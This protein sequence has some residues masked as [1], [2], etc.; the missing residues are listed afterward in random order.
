MKFFK[1]K[2]CCNRIFELLVF[3]SC[4]FL[5][6][7]FAQKIASGSSSDTS[8]FL[9]G[10]SGTPMTCG[11]SNYGQGGD[12]TY[13]ANRTIPISVVGLTDIIAMSGGL[14]HSLFLKSDGT[15]WACG[16]NNYGQ[17]GNITTGYVA[18]PLQLSGL[19]D[20]IAISAGRNHSLFLKSDGT[21][22]ACGYNNYGQLGDGSTINR[23]SP[24]QVSGL[25]GIVSLIGGQQYSLFL[26]NDG[27]V[28]GCGFNGVG[29]LGDGSTIDK[30][31]PV[32]VIGLTNDIVSIAAGISHSL[33]LK[34]DGS[35]WACG[36]NNNG[37]LG[38]G[39]TINRISPIHVSSL[40]DI[41]AIAGGGF[42]FSLF[43]KND[44]TVWSCGNNQYG[45]L[46]DGTTTQRNTPIQMVGPSCIT[47]IA[48]GWVH[49]LLLKNDTTFWSCGYNGL[50][51]LGDGTNSTRTNAVQV[52]LICCNN[53]S[54]PTISASTNPITSGSST[55]LHIEMGNLNSA[56][57]WKW[58]ANSCGGTFINTSTEISVSPTATT[59]YY[60][61]GEGGC[62][63]PGVCAS[64]T[65]IVNPVTPPSIQYNN[66]IPFILNE[67]ITPLVPI[68]SGGDV[69]A[70]IY[71]QVTTFASGFDSPYN[72]VSDTSGNVFVSDYWLNKIYKVTPAG[73]VTIFAGSGIQE[74]I[75]G[76]GEAAGF[77]RPLGMAVDLLGNLYVAD[78]FGNKI[79]KIFPTGEVT[80]YAGSGAQGSSDGSSVSA[81][82][83][84]PT[85]VVVDLSNN[86]YVA[87]RHNNKIRKI[88]TS[89]QVTTIAGSGIAGSSDGIGVT[90]SLNS[91]NGIAIDKLGQYLYIAD[92]FNHK[93]RKISLSGEVTTYAGNGSSGFADG[94]SS[95]ASF[96]QPF[97]IALDG[98]GNVY[99]G[100]RL[101]NKIRKISTTGQVTTLA[102]S[103]TYG[104]TDGIGVESS[105]Y[106]PSGVSVDTY[107]NLYVGDVSNHKIRKIAL[108][109]YTIT[110]TLPIG[111]NFEATTGIISGTPISTSPPTEYTITAN[112][113]SGSS[114]TTITLSITSGQPHALFTATPNPAA[115]NEE[116]FFD[117]SSSYHSS[118]T[119]NS[120]VTYEWDFNNDETYDATGVYASHTF[121][122]YGYFPVK[123]RVTDDNIPANT[124]TIVF[125]ISVSQGNMPPIANTGGPYT[126]RA[127][128]MLSLN[129]SNS[130]DPNATCGDSIVQYG[131]DLDNDGV[132]ET[133]GLM[134]NLTWAQL[135]S[136]GLNTAGIQTI[137]LRVTDEFG[138]VTSSDTTLTIVYPPTAT[139]QSFCSGAMVSNLVATGSNL[140]WYTT[141]TSGSSLDPTT[142]LTTNTYYVS[143][144]I[145]GVESD[146]TAVSIEILEGQPYAL[147]TASPNLA[148]CNEEV[149]FDASP[150]YHSSP[151]CNSIVT[152]E[153]DF[154]NDETY[155]AIGVN[156]SH[157][158]PTYGYFPI[159]LRVTDDNVPASTDIKVIEITVSQGNLP[160]IAN[161]GG[162]YATTL[163]NEVTL[164]ASGSSDPNTSCGDSIVNYL[165]DIDNDGAFDDATGSS[166]TLTLSQIAIL[167]IGT[168]PI[169]LQLYDTFGATGIDATTLEICTAIPIDTNENQ[170]TEITPDANTIILDHFNSSTIGQLHGA[171]NYVTSMN[172]MGNA[173]EFK[174][175]NWI[176]YNYNA[177]LSSAGTIDFWI[178]PKAY[179]IPLANINWNTSATS[180]PPAGHVFHSQI[181]A[182][183]K[184]AVGAWPSG[185][186]TSNSSIPLNTWTRIT[187]TWG[188][189][190]NIIYING[191]AD[192]VNTSVFNP[193][194]N[195]NYSI[196]FPYWG[197]TNEFYLDELHV[198]NKKRTPLEINSVF[199]PLLID[200]ELSS[201]C[202]NT[203]TNI[204]ITNPEAGISYQLFKE[205]QPYGSPQVGV[206][207]PLIFNTGNLNETTHFTI[208][209]TNPLSGCS[210]VLSGIVT[211][212]VNRF[213]QNLAI[214]NGL[215]AY[216]TFNNNAND[217]SG[218]G[219]DGTT[220]NTIPT[221]D[222]YS[223]P[224]SAFSF[225]GATSY[226]DLGDNDNLNPHLGDI[227][228]SAWVKK[229]ILEQHSRIYSKGTHGGSQ[230]GY[231]LM[232][233]GWS[234][235]TP[236]AGIFSAGGH[237]HIVYSD[238]PITD[239][240][241]HHYAVVISRSSTIS[242]YVD[243]ILQ[244]QTIDISEHATED[245]GANTYNASI[246]ASYS[247]W[248]NPGFI[249][250]FLNGSIDEVAIYNRS[251]SSDEVQIL[252]SP[253]LMAGSSVINYNTATDI[254]L[255]HSQNG[256]S[257]QLK[258]NGNNLGAPQIG[259][260]ATLTF[261][262]GNLTACSSFTMMAT[263][264][265]TNCSGLLDQTLR[266]EVIST[267][268]A[269]ADSDGFGSAA[270]PLICSPINCSPDSPIAVK[271]RIDMTGQTIE[272]GGVHLAGNFATLGSTTITH[273]WDPNDAG[274]QMQWV[275]NNIY[276]LTVLFPSNAALAQL[277]FKTLRN[278][279]WSD[280]SNEYSEGFYG[281]LNGTTCGMDNQQGSFNRKLLLPNKYMV[282]EAAWS[283]CPTTILRYVCNTGDCNDNQILYLDT[284]GDGF[285]STT[286]VACGVTNSNDCN[287]DFYSLANTCESI[288][289]LKLF[290]EGYYIGGGLMTTV[291][292]NQDFPLYLLPSSTNVE[293]ITV[294]LRDATT[295]ALVAS[296]TAMLKTDGTAVCTFPTAPSGSFYIAVKTRNTVETWSAL[297]QTVGVMP[298]SYDFTSAASQ[299]YLGNQASLGGG[300]F[301]FFSGDI[302]KNGAQDGEVNPTDYTEWEADANAFLF[303]SYATDL[304]GDGEVGPA[305]YSIWEA[306]ANA[307]VFALYP[308]AP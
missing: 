36:S 21:V 30:H 70:N 195:G 272:A 231:D 45:Q 302:D 136:Y 117:A 2:K 140:Q 248:G 227:T 162:P 300:V 113:A 256:V 250:E 258:I 39:T 105:F 60:V 275:E 299:A 230:P 172:G 225:D 298:L 191:V 146:R 26:K 216:Y 130:T 235:P 48:A 239:L 281:T 273:D 112:N 27:S 293:N 159:K 178:Y 138:A 110:P 294:E 305:D 122:T 207:N 132:F 261:N 285:G 193:A 251:L 282:F 163:S 243:G 58:Y 144:T 176:R 257:Y 7:I 15:V 192:V 128:S 98:L 228:I 102:G 74:S 223:N 145:D 116:V 28:W 40:N 85:G 247:A 100:D 76:I 64:I 199:K 46:G 196:Y 153:W 4:M 97:G 181:T 72:V 24:I 54:I 18:T 274:S 203:A 67:T 151:T 279:I 65:V 109:G 93:I 240:L 287:D 254:L 233:Y 158:F 33:F 61:R 175:N 104:A 121:S 92:Q 200:S 277:Q 126:I 16:Y 168:H 194:A 134:I 95:E 209:A 123:L 47:A 306:N 50:G 73:V 184:I 290:I 147:F 213:L 88:D 96:N 137:G 224:N 155:D 169:Q 78:F 219:I 177:N 101:N 170:L 131:W 267:L 143:Q 19:F 188:S 214:T 141:A 271:F 91:P 57:N 268:Y 52:Q 307:F 252:S 139:A 232:F 180:Y 218:N 156:A 284:D 38:D 81:S 127:G 201:I 31:I 173:A 125:E 14:S 79:R 171:M 124:D 296:T 179:N 308:A 202:N 245:I 119:S 108:T 266:I 84:E 94:V 262:S 206:N 12:G 182:A 220:Y 114:V 174:N 59:T 115:C 55:S 286:Q 278:N 160:P 297:P 189:N 120:I 259:N 53:P 237:E 270:L 210:R 289:N 244:N 301:G 208:K 3:L 260:G 304:N 5:H 204:R 264:S 29:Q 23:A 292:N 249:N 152:Y 217:E 71:G 241:W 90:A 215:Q 242:L 66:P 185:S 103:G 37:Q 106:G 211:I 99:V 253:S 83:Y 42:P 111:L 295:T 43:L 265:V 190:N 107:G 10:N 165:W 142:V 6:Q 77:N 32:Q 291:E 89:G 238:N 226:I 154:N 276:E 205:N 87:D 164:N 167:G 303:G 269:D 222:R 166:V 22:W 1:S 56:T 118:P 82:F 283:E 255:H 8:Y 17:I 129:A 198:S 246:G 157:T 212:T 35:V 80:T 9:C 49:S 234:G 69:P 51:N 150:S 13:N 135:V 63:F 133:N 197:T 183:G 161:A 34:S 280:Q 25:T 68:N 41:V 20:I 221:E 149:F 236:A 44:G 187:I 11:N 75:D 148:A 186:F 263:N 288:V 86:V 229:G 62:V